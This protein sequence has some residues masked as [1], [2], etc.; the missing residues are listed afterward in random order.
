MNSLLAVLA[1]A[2][3]LGISVVLP[4]HGPT[5]VLASAPF[6]A[7]GALAAYRVK[8]DQNLLRLFIAG[9]LVRLIVGTFIFSAGLQDFFGG[10]AKTYDELGAMQLEV[11]QQGNE[12]F[13]SVLHDFSKGG[14]WGMVYMVAGL[15][16]VIGRNML[17]VQFINSV[18]GAATVVLVYLCAM[19]IFGNRGVARAAAVFVALYPSL[20]LWS[21]QGLK[22]GPIVFCLAVAMYTTLKLGDR[23]SLAHMT[24]LVASMLAILSLRFYIFYML[25]AAVVGS[26]V[27]GIRSASTQNFARQLVAVAGIGLAMTYLGVLGTARTQIETF[28]NLERIQVS[29]SDLAQSAESGFGR[30]IDVS[31]TPGALAVIPLGSIYLLFA[32]FPWQLANL[33]QSITLP[34]MLVWWVSFPMLV[35]GLWF[36]LKYRLRQAMPIMIFTTMMTIGYSLFQGNVGTAYR[37]RAQILVFYF[38]F[39]AVGYVLLK[40]RREDRL[41]QSSSHQAAADAARAKQ[42][43]RRAAQLARVERQ[44]GRAPTTARVVA[45]RPGRD[46]EKQEV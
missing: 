25:V 28:G 6:A 2:V 11:W 44:K 21:C 13:R 18:F 42:E 26:F 9:L 19:H 38:I 41:R 32:P 1:L 3:P 10:D 37:Q 5:A 46:E 20:V 17:A 8:S 34:E 40:E 43:Q 4:E 29:R 27:I 36:T 23:I 39:V 31:T 16:G 7:V 22:D 15:Y 24:A 12:Y 33:R 45:D 14:G 35:L 30:D